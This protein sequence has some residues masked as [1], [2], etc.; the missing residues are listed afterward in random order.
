MEV[1]F[2]LQVCGNYGTCL[3]TKSMALCLAY[4]TGQLILFS[5][6]GRTL[7]YNRCWSELSWNTTLWICILNI[8]SILSCMSCLWK[9]FAAFCSVAKKYHFVHH[10]FVLYICLY[11]G[12]EIIV[13]KHI[14]HEWACFLV[15]RWCTKLKKNC[16]TLLDAEALGRVSRRWLNYLSL[17]NDLVHG[18]GLDFSLQR[19]VEVCM[20]SR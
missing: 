13:L 6:W 5:F 9:S 18:W 20:L 4:Y 2:T 3:F 8:F 17:Q 16:G 7:H 19:C 15:I 14:C 10:L 1:F 12:F 11:I